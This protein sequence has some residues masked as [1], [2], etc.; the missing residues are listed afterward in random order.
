METEIRVL[1]E[2]D[3]PAAERFL[4]RQPSGMAL[5]GYLAKDTLT[6]KYGLYAGVLEGGELVSM[7]AYLGG[8]FHLVAPSR[9]EA[10]LALLGKNR[11][12]PLRQINGPTDRV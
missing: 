2:A 4:K 5:R 9:L 3:H 12:G 6:P 10:L 11:S 7:A 1:G 8:T